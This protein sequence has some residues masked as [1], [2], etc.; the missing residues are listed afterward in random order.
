MKS[1]FAPQD[2]EREG[3][4]FSE[5]TAREWYNSAITQSAV[6]GLARDASRYSARQSAAGPTAVRVRVVCNPMWEGSAL[7]DYKAFSHAL[8][9][10][11]S[12]PARSLP[13]CCLFHHLITSSHHTVGTAS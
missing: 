3:K 8:W 10:V 13:P 6:K 7:S 11:A 4:S 5:Q 1:F 9:H 12:D 2:E